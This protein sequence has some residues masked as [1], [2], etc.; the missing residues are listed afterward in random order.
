MLVDTDDVG[1]TMDFWNKVAVCGDS[2]IH[3]TSAKHMQHVSLD[4]TV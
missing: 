3:S 2:G 1:P 4:L